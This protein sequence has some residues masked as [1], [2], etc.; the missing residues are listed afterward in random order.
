MARAL[1]AQD[2]VSLSLLV[3]SAMTHTSLGWTH[4]T[5]YA[6]GDH[7]RSDSKRDRVDRPHYRGDGGAAGPPGGRWISAGATTSAAPR[8]S[9]L[10]ERHPGWGGW[11]SISGDGGK[12]LGAPRA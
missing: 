4:E 10:T 6:K 7:V 5:G 9:T 12:V 1:V 8:Q 2:R 3:G 11:R